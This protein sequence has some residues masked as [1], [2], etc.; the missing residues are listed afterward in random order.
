MTRVY[1]AYS[2]FSLFLAVVEYSL[3]CG[4]ILQGKRVNEEATIKN[5]CK[6]GEL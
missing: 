3:A 2:I 4:G 5:V 6:V 1:S